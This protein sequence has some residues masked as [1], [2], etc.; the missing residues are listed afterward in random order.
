VLIPE[1]KAGFVLGA[2]DFGC[3]VVGPECP[4]ADNWGRGL[5]PGSRGLV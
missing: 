5:W 1:E 2:A 4:E 3:A